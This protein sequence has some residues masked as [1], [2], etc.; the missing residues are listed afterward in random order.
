MGP[1]GWSHRYLRERIEKV[2][3]EHSW[4]HSAIYPYFFADRRLSYVKVRFIDKQNDKTFRQW[5]ISSNGVWVSRR[6]A[7]KAPLLYRLNTLAA[8]EVIFICS[9]EKAADRGV[10]DLGITTTSTSDGEG[11]WSGEYTKPLVGN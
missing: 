10:A 9:G 5:A 7:G 2:E 11:Q 8:A 6:K 3:H 4:R 1:A